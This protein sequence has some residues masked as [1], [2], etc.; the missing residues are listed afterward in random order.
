MR[1]TTDLNREPC[2]VVAAEGLRIAERLKRVKHKL[3]TAL[4]VVTAVVVATLSSMT[5]TDRPAQAAGGGSWDIDTWGGPPRA[6]DNAVLKWNHELLDTIRANPSRTGPTITARALGVV[7]T[8]MYDAWAAYDADAIPTRPDGQQRRP[9]VR[10][11]RPDGQ[12]PR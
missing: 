11:R 12:V 10:L 2:C 3:V 1:S 7:H 6:G 8:A 5:T 9:P 4:L